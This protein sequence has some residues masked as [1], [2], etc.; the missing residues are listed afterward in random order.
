MKPKYKTYGDLLES[1]S[2]EEIISYIL[3]QLKIEHDPNNP[4][5][6][7]H[8]IVGLA[9]MEFFHRGERKAQKGETA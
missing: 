2:M 4:R 1:G 6:K 3:D 7:A 8:A 9:M 5:D